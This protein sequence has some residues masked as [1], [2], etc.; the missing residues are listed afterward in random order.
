MQIM[1]SHYLENLLASDAAALNPSQTLKNTSTKIAQQFQDI[2]AALFSTQQSLTNSRLL[3]FRLQI[4]SLDCLLMRFLCR[5]GTTTLLAPAAQ[6]N[7]ICFLQSE[8]LAP[9]TH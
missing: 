5:V 6:E 2:P 9:L 7:Y 1:P 3:A 4:T 8:E